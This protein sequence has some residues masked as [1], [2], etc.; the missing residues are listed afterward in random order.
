MEKVENKGGFIARHA[1]IATVLAVIFGATSGV[2]G[3]VITA[4]SMAI[5]FW[6]L[7]IALPFFIIPTVINKEKRERFVAISSKD[8]IWCFVAGAF[9]FGHFFSW[10]NAVKF[11][12]IASASV[13]AALHPLVVL[14]VT[15]LIYKR[16]VSWKSIVA[17]AVA[18]IGGAIIVGADYGTFAG[19]NLK[20]NIYAF[21]AAI[22]MGLYF[23]VGDSVRKRVDGGLYVLLVFLSCWLCF[24]VGMIVSNT[25]ALGYPTQDYLLLVVMALIC[26]IGAHAVFNLCIGHVSSLYVSTWESGDPVFSTIMAIIFLQQIPTPYELVG[27]VIV[28]CALLYYNRQESRG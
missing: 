12:N 18:L 20:G 7:T 9:L 4:P 13:L 19:G 16:K 23:S 2:L 1:K 27:C 15:I 5:G 25:D 17:I 22:F 3:S 6:R 10:F 8:C 28:V 11:T 21:F 14:L 26:Q 24:S